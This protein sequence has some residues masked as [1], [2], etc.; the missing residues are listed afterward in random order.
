MNQSL[1][2]QEKLLLLLKAHENKGFDLLYKLYGKNLYEITVKIVHDRAMA[3]DVLQ[4]S[5]VK[6][7]LHM[8]DY[9]SAKGSLFTW[10]LNITRNTAIDRTRSLA[11]QSR[12]HCSSRLDEGDRKVTNL[13]KQFPCFEQQTDTIGLLNYVAL[14]EEDHREVIEHIYLKGYTHVQTSKKLQIPLGTVKSR[15]KRAISLLQTFLL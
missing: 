10:L 5:F 4:D 14:L 7:W 8:A 2:T 11:Y 9:D 12:I 6:I 3:E 13:Y 1:V 15:L